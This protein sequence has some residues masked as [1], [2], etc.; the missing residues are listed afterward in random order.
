[1]CHSLN[2]IHQLRPFIVIFH[3]T[4][5]H[6]VTLLWN[7][8]Q[9]D[10]YTLNFDTCNPNLD[11]VTLTLLWKPCHFD[12]YT[13]NL[14]MGPRMLISSTLCARVVAQYFC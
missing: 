1:M 5:T 4:A 11:H 7:L 6:F 10:V 9:F 3:Y 2:S 12:V 14:D 8:L 13:R